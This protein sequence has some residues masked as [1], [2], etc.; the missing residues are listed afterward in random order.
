M[1]DVISILAVLIES[2]TRLSRRFGAVYKHTK[3]T[4]GTV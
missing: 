3:C 1:G 4:I 2:R